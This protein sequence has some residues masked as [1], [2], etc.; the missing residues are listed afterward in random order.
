MNT[1]KEQYFIIRCDRAGVFYAQIIEHKDLPSGTNLLIAN[2]RKA[3]GWDG[4]CAVEELAVNGPQVEG[5][6]NR[7]TVR[8]PEMEVASAIQIIPV[9]DAAKARIEAMPEWKRAQ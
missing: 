4:A 1:N 9:T 7:W 6:G 3:H 2:A 8:V 5:G